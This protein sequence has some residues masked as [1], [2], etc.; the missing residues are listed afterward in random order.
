VPPRDF[1]SSDSLIISGLFPAIVTIS[2]F[3]DDWDED[4]MKFTLQINKKYNYINLI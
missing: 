3:V 4:G 1:T 2:R